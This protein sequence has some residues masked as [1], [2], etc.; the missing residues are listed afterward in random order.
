MLPPAVRRC[1]LSLAEDPPGLVVAVSGGPDS[2][3]LL[4]ALLE[5]RGEEPTPL[6]VAH[7]NHQL[8]GPDSDA[9]EAFVAGLH[10][11]LVQNGAAHLHLAGRRLDVARLAAGEGGNL[12]AVARRER[13][14]WLAE[15]ARGHGLRHVATGHTASDQA[16]TVLHHLLRGAGIDGLRG[17]APRRPLEQGVEVVRPLLGV[18][19]GQ[20]LT[21]LHGLG[22]PARHDASNDDRRL[23]RNRIRHELLP[24]LAEHYNPRVEDVLNRLAAQA[25][26]VCAEEDQAADDLLRQAELPRAA[27]LVV[28]D[29]GRLGQAPPRLVRCALRRLW[30]R[31]GWPASE[32]GFAHWRRLGE[33]A[34]ADAGAHDLPGGVHARRRGGVL[35]LRGPG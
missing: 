18:T 11:A 35:Q 16:E 9:D 17:I 19:R 20:V 13:Y 29:A 12:E 25:Q 5:A 15:V 2:V 4:R 27:A 3:A 6:V 7:L 34:A 30:R 10:A 32:M 21:Y 8:R 31:E 1:W 28:L 24:L 22:Q 26:E 23:T 14:R 33:L